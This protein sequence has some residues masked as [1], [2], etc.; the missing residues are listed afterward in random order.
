MEPAQSTTECDYSSFSNDLAL[1]CVSQDD[2]KQRRAAGAGIYST[3][4]QSMSNDTSVLQKVHEKH[5]MKTVH[6][7]S[8]NLLKCAWT[9]LFLSQRRSK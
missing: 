6:L 7:F 1:R 3:E 2:V 8:M 4:A 9:R 5:E